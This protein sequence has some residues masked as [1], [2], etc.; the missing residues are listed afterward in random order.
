MGRRFPPRQ[1]ASNETEDPAPLPRP[2]GT[3][4]TGTH[5]PLSGT[6]APNPTTPQNSRPAHRYG[7]APRA[8]RPT[9]AM[10]PKRGEK[11]PVSRTS[12]TP[13]SWREDSAEAPCNVLP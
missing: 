2:P 12:R 10:T 1:A 13:Q 9:T 3:R 8:R 7:S 6:A 5:I 4:E 11:P